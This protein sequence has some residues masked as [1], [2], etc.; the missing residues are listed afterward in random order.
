MKIQLGDIVL[1]QLTKDDAENIN[2]R[3]SHAS[4]NQ[5]LMRICK[6]GYQAHFGNAVG[7]GIVVAM[8]ITK[9]WSDICINGQ[10]ILDGNDSLWVTNVSKGEGPGYWGHRV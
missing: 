2:R 8:I 9:V 6:T 5:D 7:E 4:H 1:Y 3:Y 10:T